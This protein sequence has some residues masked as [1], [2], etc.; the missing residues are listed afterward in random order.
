MNHHVSPDV[1]LSSQL[2]EVNEISNE[3]NAVIPSSSSRLSLASTQHLSPVNSFNDGSQTGDFDPL[4]ARTDSEASTWTG[5]GE[6]ESPNVSMHFADSNDSN[7]EP[8]IT[9]NTPRTTLNYNFDMDWRRSLSPPPRELFGQAV[10]VASLSS[11]GSSSDSEGN[12]ETNVELSPRHY[13]DDNADLEET[14]AYIANIL[15]QQCRHI[16]INFCFYWRSVKRLAEERERIFKK[17]KKQLS[18]SRRFKDGEV[19]RINADIELIEKSINTFMPVVPHFKAVYQKDSNKSIVIRKG[20]IYERIG[21]KNTF[22]CIF[23]KGAFYNCQAYLV[24]DDSDTLME[25]SFGEHHHTGTEE[26]I[27]DEPLPH[28]VPV[29]LPRVTSEGEGYGKYSKLTELLKNSQ[30][31][32]LEWSRNATFCSKKLELL[33]GYVNDLE[34][35]YHPNNKYGILCKM[36]IAESK[37]LLK[38]VRLDI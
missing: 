9:V 8:N 12:E 2:N 35:A 26:Y 11:V 34:A 31:E 25:N 10:D 30:A 3:R 17:L 14:D 16:V 28:A 20:F 38:N 22:K 23:Q 13:T 29:L 21:E 15:S 33:R 1:S 18:K 7:S 27:E 19:L 32:L 37:N 36:V 5:Y 24:T 6:G 4:L